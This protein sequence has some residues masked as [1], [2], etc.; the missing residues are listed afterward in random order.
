V[1]LFAFEVD[2][3]AIRNADSIWKRSAKTRC[4]IANQMLTSGNGLSCSSRF[5]IV[6]GMRHDCA[7]QGRGE[8][9]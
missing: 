4:A 8:A 1:I 7:D 2:H 6:H 5:W 3:R 9:R